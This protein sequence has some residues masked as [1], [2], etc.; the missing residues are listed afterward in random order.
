MSARSRIL[1][2]GILCSLVAACGGCDGAQAGY[3]GS[4]GPKAAADADDPRDFG[5]LPDFAL[6]SQAGEIVTL[7]SLRGRVWVMASIFTTCAGPC[8]RI[9]R[10]MGD[11]ARRIENTNA[12]LVSITVDPARDNPAK[13]A[14]YA[15]SY[16]A[17]PERWT[18][19][20]GAE[21][22]IHTLIRE[23][24]RMPVAR[25]DE[26]HPET[27]DLLTHD[28]RLAVIDAEGRIRGWYDSEDRDQLALLV[29]RVKFLERAAAT[30]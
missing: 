5:A 16:G 12:H 11:V 8:P 3:G 15:K 13:L 21:E 18:F 24:F 20:T 27:G 28:R 29:E 22:A 6:T 1:A 4:D 14:S 17:D 2:A 23:G 7:A 26:P 30:D 25:L 10:A 19:L 9:T